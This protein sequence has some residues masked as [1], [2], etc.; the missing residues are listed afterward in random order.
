[1]TFFEKYFKEFFEYLWL[2]ETN[3]IL[4]FCFHRSFNIRNIYKYI[5]IVLHIRQKEEWF[6]RWNYETIILWKYNKYL[7]KILI[8]IIY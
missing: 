3:K 6:D 2:F 1:M 8:W 5:I 4:E 7:F